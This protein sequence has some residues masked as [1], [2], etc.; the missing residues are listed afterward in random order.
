[1]KVVKLRTFWC[2]GRFATI[3][4]RCLILFLFLILIFFE[5]L[6]I[7]F[8]TLL[9]HFILRHLLSL[10]ISRLLICLRFVKLKL[11]IR[12]CDLYCII[13]CFIFKVFFFFLLLFDFFSSL[14]N[15]LESTKSKHLFILLLSCHVWLDN[16]SP[17]HNQTI[18]ICASLNHEPISN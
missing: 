3:L 4:R 7:L 13:G 11:F 14:L 16:L 12:I 10:L 6:C 8:L 1:M 18:N 17:L 9:L 15:N 5:S 2:R